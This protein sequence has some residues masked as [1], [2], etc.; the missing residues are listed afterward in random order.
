MQI[1]KGNVKLAGPSRIH[2]K[3]AAAGNANCRVEIVAVVASQG[4]YR[5]AF[6]GN[7]VPLLV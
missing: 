3:S 4:N 5:I 2:V 1:L 7:T 6:A